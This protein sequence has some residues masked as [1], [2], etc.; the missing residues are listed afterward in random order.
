MQ[1]DGILSAV[2]KEQLRYFYRQLHQHFHHMILLRKKSRKKQTEN[3]TTKKS[4]RG[5][6][7][8]SKPKVVEEKS[9]REKNTR[10][11]E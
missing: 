5:D 11:G 7:C 2:A 4:S 6:I 9:T 8:N 10:Q 1:F 3:K